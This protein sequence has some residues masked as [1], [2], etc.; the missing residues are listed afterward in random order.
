[1]SRR[2]LST[3]V[4]VCGLF[5]VSACKQS[6]LTQDVSPSE[7]VAARFV[8]G[9]LTEA[10][11]LREAQRLP[12]QLRE[13]FEAGAGRQEFVRSLVD[14]RLLAQE[15]SLQFGQ[16]PEIRR[17]VRELEERLAIEALLAA[18]ERKAP[19]LT[20][21]E[22]R[23][24]YDSHSERFAEPERVRL[25]RVLAAVPVGSPRSAWEQAR[26]RAE[27][28]RKR[29]ASGEALS[30]V[31]EAGD[32]PE[33]T[34]GGDLGLL[35]VG[36]LGAESLEKA[37]AALS[38]PGSVS[39]VIDTA[40]GAAVLVLIERRPARIPP[41]EEVRAAVVGQM[42]PTHQRK[43]LSELLARLRASAAVRLEAGSATSAAKSGG[44][45]ARH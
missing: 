36:S 26:Q 15:A 32:G 17:Q 5:A 6:G 20:D 27:G 38:K 44:A 33:R 37:A 45:V 28:L 24:Y 19:A 35:A 3:A 23:A 41:F 22:A 29:L 14:K 21:A 25:A 30:K 39:P 4:A 43:V 12:P 11:V 18:E 13:K 16:D 34:R 2:F 8:G 40:D 10:E 31:A 1:M 7:P 42:K 9:V